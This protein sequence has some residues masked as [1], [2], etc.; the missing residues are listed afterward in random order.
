MKPLDKEVITANYD[1]L[2]RQTP[3]YEVLSY[4]HEVEILNRRQVSEILRYPP[5]SRN[6]KLLNVL[7]KCGPNS[8]HE[9]INS[10]KYSNCDLLVNKL[11]S[12]EFGIQN[13]TL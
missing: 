3:T 1:L 5:S 11:L 8:F 7:Q 6:R 12:L 10:L 9:F 4:L 2:I 13:M